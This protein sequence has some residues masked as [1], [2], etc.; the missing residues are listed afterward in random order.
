MS[1][2]QPAIGTIS[3]P[4]PGTPGA[5][6]DLRHRGTPVDSS[7]GHVWPTVE[8]V[9]TRVP[10]AGTRPFV[11]EPLAGGLTNRNYRAQG[12]DGAAVVVRLTSPQS[13]LLTIDRAA[14]RANAS[15]AA[16]AGVAPRILAFQPELGATVT[17]WIAGRTLH[18]TD[19]DDARTLER[20]A[21][22]CRQLHAGPRFGNDFDMFAV[23]PRYLKI[24]RDRGFRLPPG[25]L[26]FQPQA[27]QIEKALGRNPGRTVP[28]HNDLLAANIMVQPDRV[29]LIDY[30]YSGNNDPCF[31]LGNIWSEA[32]LAPERLDELVT[33][34]YGRYDPERIARARLQGVMSKY[35][36]M[37][38]ASIQEATSDASFDFWSW[39]LE[40]YERAIAEFEGPDFA[41]LI[42]AAMTA[43]AAMPTDEREPRGEQE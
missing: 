16:S 43:R 25:Y 28:C 24:V 18:P 37:L 33:A 29:W 10:A 17:E 36:W 31:E 6:S 41:R 39:G 38:W 2:P 34:Y 1:S 5:A 7:P 9:L 11:V 8:D 32:A 23:Q 26:D 35:G 21:D 12:A 30:E 15:A 20:I 40:K 42:D 27:A 13:G 22:A 3:P 14:E 19:L 4:L